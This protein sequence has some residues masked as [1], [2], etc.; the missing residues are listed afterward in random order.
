MAGSNDGVNDQESGDASGEDQ[1]SS[2]DQESTDLGKVDLSKIT[3]PVLKSYVEQQLKDAKEARRQAAAER[4][5]RREAQDKVDK[6]ERDK[7]TE[8]QRAEADRKALEADRDALAKRLAERELSDAVTDAAKTALAISPTAV[9]KQIRDDIEIDTKTGKATN[10]TQLITALKASD[11]YMFKRVDGDAGAGRG[12]PNGG[13][14]G[15]MNAQLR[16][17]VRGPGA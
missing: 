6:F 11:P 7:M 16:A 17:Y 12:T 5:A 8:A 2:Q 4:R 14:A 10:V 15:D 13:Q 1:E 3:D 9:W